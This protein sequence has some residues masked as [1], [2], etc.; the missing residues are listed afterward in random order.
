MA[1]MREAAQEN[2]RVLDDPEPVVHFE[3]FADSSL[4][5]TLRAYTGALSDRLPATTEL[6]KAIDRK[7]RAAGIVIAF[8]QRDVHFHSGVGGAVSPIA[9]SDGSG[10][11]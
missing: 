1:L 8:P 2:P 9:G 7:F 3:Q 4:S 10:D 11:R 6:H 5:L